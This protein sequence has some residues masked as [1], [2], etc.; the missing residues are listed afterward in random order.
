MIMMDNIATMGHF[1]IVPNWFFGYNIFFEVI[2]AI[3]TLL[4]SFYAFKV[5]R[6]SGQ[7]QSKL[8]GM[9]FLFISAAYSIQSL[10]NFSNLFNPSSA[11]C[12]M[13]NVSSVHYFDLAGIYA[14]VI[15]FIIGLIT[16]AYM[17]FRV[18]DV[19]L[20]SLLLAIVLL[21]LLLSSNT[22]FMFYLLSSVLLFYITRHYLENY[23]DNK[24]AKTLLV[25]IGFA[26]LLFGKIH[27]IFALNHGAYYVAG[28]FL[29]FV[30]YAL[31]LTNLMMVVRKNEQ[32]AR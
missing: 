7:R 15:F 13:M 17:T 11:T 12:S 5:Y 8:F 22:F 32:K 10:V 31:I 26:F 19:K 27:F 14:Y 18:N 28:H 1:V 24:Q 25:L 30:A 9:S 2:F 16:L 6:I 3:V 4:V 23:F 21:A 20:Y 29:E